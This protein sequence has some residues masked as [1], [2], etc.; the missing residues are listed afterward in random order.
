MKKGYLWIIF[1]FLFIATSCQSSDGSS[2]VPIEITSTV[3][4]VV[5]AETP[6]VLTPTPTVFIEPTDEPIASTPTQMPTATAPATAT[7]DPFAHLS[8]RIALLGSLGPKPRLVGGGARDTDIYVLHIDGEET[9][10]QRYTEGLYA[11]GHV[12]WSPDGRK[13]SFVGNDLG[14]A[15]DVLGSNTYLY[16]LDLDSF[17]LTPFVTGSSLV[18]S[19]PSIWLDNER[20]LV[21]QRDTLSRRVLVVY[22]LHTKESYQLIDEGE[23]G[24]LSELSPVLSP[25]GCCIAYSRI[26]PNDGARIRIVNQ[27][28]ALLIETEPFCD[29]DAIG[30]GKVANSLT[31]L[32]DNQ[33]IKFIGGFGE[34]YVM[35]TNNATVQYLGTDFPSYSPPD[36]SPDRTQVAANQ[37]ATTYVRNVSDS[38]FGRELWSV[39]KLGISGNTQPAWSPDGNCVAYVIRDGDGTT[40]NLYVATAD[41]TVHRR[42]T[43]NFI[44]GAKIAWSPDSRCGE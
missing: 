12:V 43:E 16:V 30:C 25:D 35:Q 6:T 26:Q 15:P 37:S 40:Q 9:E 11:G 42:L 18:Q 23:V 29:L 17:Q 20:L 44:V 33:T 13:L 1:I 21:T 27:E 28:G 31:W 10:L 39:G 8:G 32:P 24:N 3:E 5:P 4:M 38:D 36:W 22:D 2:S 19:S 14:N 34:Y 41:G 7:P